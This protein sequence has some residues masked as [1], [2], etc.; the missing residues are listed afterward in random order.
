M[1]TATVRGT[2]GEA[3]RELRRR[4]HNADQGLHVDPSKLTVG[5]F[6]DRWLADWAELK[7]SPKSLERYSDVVRV[8]IKPRIGALKLQKL[9]ILHLTRLYSTLMK[10]APEGSGLAPA[11]VSYVHRVIHRGL[12]QAKLWKLIQSNPAAD[13]EPPRTQRREVEILSI[14]AVDTLRAALSGRD[15]F[16]IAMTALGTGM[17]RGELLALRWQDLDLTR[18][19]LA[20]ISVERSLEETSKGGLRFK[21]PKTKHSRRRISIP[22]YLREELRA[23]WKAQQ[24]IRLQLGIGKAA[25]DALVF[26][27]PDGTPRKPGSV[28]KEWGRLVNAIAIPKVSFHALRHTHASQLIASGMD[29]LTISRRLGH[30]SPTVT[31]NIYGHLFPDSD[32]RAARALDAAFS[33]AQTVNLPRSDR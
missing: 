21:E 3:E 24:E 2:K 7:L 19:G 11:T 25:D 29:V 5:E 4:L 22:D 17:R 9:E 8:N 6:F 20:Q 27:Q 16:P 26:A 30:S 1:A 28:T 18:N 12:G 14:R 10:P 23:Y 13:A 32:E 15:I 31:L 33:G